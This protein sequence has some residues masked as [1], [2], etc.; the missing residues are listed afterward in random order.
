M[1]LHSIGALAFLTLGCVNSDPVPE[2]PVARAAYAVEIYAVD[3]LVHPPARGATMT[4]DA[5]LASI[6][7]S[8]GGDAA[9]GAGTTLEMVKDQLIVGNV[10]S[11]RE[12]IDEM[13]RRMRH[14]AALRE[15]ESR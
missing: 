11:V 3:D 14:D 13:L 6:R 7:S 8:T 2:R 5:L 1:R 4:A 12:S 15:S 10:P 9:W